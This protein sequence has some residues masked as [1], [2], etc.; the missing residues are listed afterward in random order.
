MAQGSSSAAE[1]HSL[2]YSSPLRPPPPI[3]LLVGNGED[4][5]YQIELYGSSRAR[6]RELQISPASG[7]NLE[8]FLSKKK[9]KELDQKS[10]RHDFDFDHD[11]ESRWFILLVPQMIDFVLEI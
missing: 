3:R 5:P 11:K 8:F 7:A 2:E 1:G 10:T 4:E 9:K 6:E